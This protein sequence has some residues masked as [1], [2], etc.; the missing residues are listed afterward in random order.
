MARRLAPRQSARLVLMLAVLSAPA[1]AGLPALRDALAQDREYLRADTSE[2]KAAMQELTT[3]AEFGLAEAHVMLAAEYARRNTW[4]D[5]EAASTHYQLAFEG[6][7]SLALGDYA[8]ML[9]KRPAMIETKAAWFK[10]ALPQ[11]P[12]FASFSSVRNTLDVYATFP[13]PFSEQAVDRLHDLYMRGCLEDCQGDY[14]RGLIADRR[15]LLDEAEQA[16][17]SAAQQSLRG[18]SAYFEF[19]GR[20]EGLKERFESFVQELEPE[21]ETLPSEVVAGI[22]QRLQTLN[23]SFSPLVVQWL[24]RAIAMGESEALL[25]R[26]EYMLALPEAFSYDDTAALIEQVRQ[27]HPVRADLL[28]ATLMTTLAWNRLDPESARDLLEQLKAAGSDEAWVGMGD[29]YS[30]GGLDEVDQYAAIREYEAVAARGNGAAFQKIA[31]IYRQGRSICI[32]HAR[33]FA[34]AEFAQQLGEAKA[35]VFIAELR[36]KLDDA[37]VASLDSLRAEL[38]E[39]FPSRHF[40]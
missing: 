3:L 10:S 27:T 2:S 16:Y 18:L 15:N 9:M 7:Y 17:A 1:S 8:R 38:K 14:Y 21:A 11:Y 29:L 32:D 23:E 36:P 34:Y 40:R 4:Q 12:W 22:G 19:L 30:M 5:L 39:R 24:D 20:S 33:A 35:S 6:G 26:I 31:Q 13:E 37:A 28:K 25:S